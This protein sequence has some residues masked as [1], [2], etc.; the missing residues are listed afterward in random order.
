MKQRNNHTFLLYIYFYAK[1]HIVLETY[2]FTNI[3]HILQLFQ[4]CTGN[5]SV[6]KNVSLMYFN[7]LRVI[8]LDRDRKCMFG[9]V[10]Q[11]YMNS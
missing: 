4:S 9:S 10:S 11:C 1:L 8:Y 2:D 6:R 5:L 7:G 3:L